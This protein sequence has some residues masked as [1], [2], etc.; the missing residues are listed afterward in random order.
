MV[1]VVVNHV[2]SLTTAT[3]EASLK[4][5]P[6]LLWQNPT[7]FHPQCW[8]DYSNATSVEQW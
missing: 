3:D 2:A 1:D 5:Q 7:D 6:D 8:I 4:S